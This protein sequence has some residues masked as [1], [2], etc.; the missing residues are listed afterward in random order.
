M[1]YR[2]VGLDVLAA[3][4]GPG[5]VHKLTHCMTRLR[6]E[7]NDRDQVDVK[8][9]EAVD[10]VLKIIEGGGQFQVVIG[11]SV[12]ESY[13]AIQERLGE[14]GPAAV[15]SAGASG[16]TKPKDD[17]NLWQRFLAM[18][19][20]IFMPALPAY[21]AAG[22][23]KA[24]LT[25]LS[26]AG[27]VD[28]A[29]STYTVIT[30]AADAVFYFLPLLLAVTSAKVFEMSL[31]LAVMLAGMLLHPTFT[32]LVTAGSPVDIFGLPIRLT[33]YN[34]TVIPIIL[35]VWVGSYVEKFASKIL[36]EVIKYVFRPLIVMVV[37]IPLSLCVLGPIG[38]YAGDALNA[39]M[40]MIDA[41]VP[42]LLPVLVGTFAPLLVLFGLNNSLVPIISTQLATKGYETVTGPGMLAHN[43][44]EGAASLAM[45]VKMKHNA[46]VRQEAVS[47]GLTALF[48]ITEPALYGVT[49]RYK[50]VLYCVMIGGGVAGAFAGVSGL[51]RY[52]MAAPGLAT[53]PTYMSLDDPSNLIKAVV[54]LVI[55]FVVTFVLVLVAKTPDTQNEA[56][57]AD[58]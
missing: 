13:N 7:F 27:L 36:P 47:T 51:V 53:L 15:T 33:S 39:F 38:A 3:V 17:R 8:A 34:A 58:E 31:G 10:G 49:L 20:G 56:S 6:F 4:G 44:A 46:K 25:V 32:G 19:A 14:A 40:N 24:V 55:A 23:V 43:I 11:P 45:A 28:T 37:M 5:N 35:I 29:S 12:N 52:V 57:T 48:G 30:F 22:M 2:K 18:I 41:T 1:D 9:V 42:W 26:A 50:N 21:I 54:T 16:T